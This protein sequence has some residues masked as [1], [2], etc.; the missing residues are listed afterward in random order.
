[1]TAGHCS[2]MAG[3]L[4]CR[5]CSTCLMNQPKETS[6]RAR[7]AIIVAPS[8]EEVLREQYPH[9]RAAHTVLDQ[10]RALAQPND[11]FV[12]GAAVL[13]AQPDP[14]SLFKRTDT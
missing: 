12:D 9:A 14:G 10:V 11:H 13:A 1:M 2:V 3:P 5:L 6:S 4:P 7:H 8:K